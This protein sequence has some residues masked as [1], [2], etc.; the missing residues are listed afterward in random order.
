MTKTG[1]ADEYFIYKVTCF[2]NV[3][4]SSNCTREMGFALLAYSTYS[5]V[6][7]EVAFQNGL[8]FWCN[9]VYVVLLQIIS[10]MAIIKWQSSKQISCSK[11]TRIFTV[12]R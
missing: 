3:R 8:V 9:A 4:L 11:N 12:Q 7:L 5:T 2:L 6:K 1:T 10:T